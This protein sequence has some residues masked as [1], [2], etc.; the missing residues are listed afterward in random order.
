MM[1]CVTNT[2]YDSLSSATSDFIAEYSRKIYHFYLK[3]RV[4]NFLIIPGDKDK[5]T[6]YSV[7]S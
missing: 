1:Q 6:H 3:A 5:I 7:Y 4:Q 2:K